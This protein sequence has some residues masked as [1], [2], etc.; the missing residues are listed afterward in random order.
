[1]LL[2]LLVEVVVEKVILLLV[3]EIPHQQIQY[4]DMLVVLEI[5]HLGLLVQVEEVEV[6]PKLEKLLLRQMV[7]M[8]AMEQPI[9]IVQV[10]V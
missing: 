1:M 6:L 7:E 3:L 5:V 8:V 10:Q 9:L 4:K 2:V